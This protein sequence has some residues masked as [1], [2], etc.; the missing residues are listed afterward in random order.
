MG[1]RQWAKNSNN[2]LECKC[3]FFKETYVGSCPVFVCLKG[4]HTNSAAFKDGAMVPNCVRAK[5]QV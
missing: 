1:E 5:N 2:P 4:S 3:V